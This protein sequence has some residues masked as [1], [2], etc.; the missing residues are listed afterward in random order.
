MPSLCGHL[1]NQLLAYLLRHLQ[2]HASALTTVGG[3]WAFTAING[4]HVEKMCMHS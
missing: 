1:A 4:I 2:W 3:G